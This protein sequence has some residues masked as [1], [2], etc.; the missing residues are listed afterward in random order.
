M[1]DNNN[2]KVL[3]VLQFPPPVHGSS[4]VGQYIKNSALITSSFERRFIN[5]SSSRD[6]SEIGAMSFKKAVIYFSILFQTLKALLVFHP[7][8]CYMAPTAKGIGFYK[9]FPIILLFRLFR[10][11]TVLHFHN[12]GVKQYQ[13][14]WL[15]NKLYRFI[16]HRSKVILLSNRLY[17]DVKKYVTLKDIFIC[18]N[19]IPNQSV[20]RQ[21]KTDSTVYL[22]FLSNMMKAKG[23]FDLLEACNILNKK[24]L[25]FKCDF[26]GKWADI[27]EEKFNHVVKEK[28]ITDKVSAHGAKYGQEKELFFEKADIFIFPTHYVNECFP[29]VLL[30]AMQYGL[31]VLSTNEGGIPD[32]VDYGITGYIVEKQNSKK[33]V[34]KIEELILNP[35]LREK[36]GKA[37]QEKFQKQ[38]TSNIFEKRMCEIIHAVI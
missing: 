16:F 15:D 37:G 30:E 17:D 19:G 4:I 10:R 24:G 21:K 9:D 27:S 5:S 36:M 13:D 22:L 26:V 12:K 23:V 2:P 33:L 8:L 20:K 25:N 14:K 3:F 18:P 7:H 1:L 29:L 11:K 31:P 38:Y 35:E 28:D 32:I 6:M 34:D